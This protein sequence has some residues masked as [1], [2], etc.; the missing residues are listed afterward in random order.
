MSYIIAYDGTDPCAKPADRRASR[1]SVLTAGFFLA[2]LLLTKLFWPKG[3]AMLRQI[4]LPG[5]P[6]VTERA[7][8]VL[9]DDLREGEPVGDALK[10]FCGEIMTHAKYPD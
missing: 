3:A 1:L 9:V 4:I 2:F 10:T 7:V 8:S 5:D 6:E